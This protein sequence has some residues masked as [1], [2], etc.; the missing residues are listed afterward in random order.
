MKTLR[1]QAIAQMVIAK[2]S[3]NRRTSGQ[4]IDVAVNEGD[5]MLLG[6]CDS[7]DQRL[8]AA[9]ITAGTYGVRSVIDKVRVRCIAPSI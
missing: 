9:E 3:E 2:L 6:W 1:E 8:I 4:T 7:E 5:V